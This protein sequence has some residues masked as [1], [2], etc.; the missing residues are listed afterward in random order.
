MPTRD[1]IADM[2]VKKAELALAEA[3][4]LFGAGFFDGAISRA[5]VSS[6]QIMKAAITLQG[7]PDDPLDVGECVKAWA[8]DGRLPAAIHVFFGVAMMVRRDADETVRYT[9]QGSAEKAIEAAR[10]FSEI[11]RQTVGMNSAPPTSINSQTFRS[12]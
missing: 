1:R 6:I 10:Q 5:S 12:I 7:R 8:M 11:V 3:D 2:H 9:T 4:L